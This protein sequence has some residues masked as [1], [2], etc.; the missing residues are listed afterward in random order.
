VIL[1][2][3]RDQELRLLIIWP[4]KTFRFIFRNLD[5][6]KCNRSALDYSLLNTKTMLT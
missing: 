5:D 6:S 1:T 4:S 3:K 2:R